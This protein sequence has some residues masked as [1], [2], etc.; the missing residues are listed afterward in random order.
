ML[1]GHARGEGGGTSSI[2]DV[3]GDTLVVCGM[4]QVMVGKATPDDEIVQRWKEGKE[5]Q[6]TAVISLQIVPPS[7]SQGFPS[8]GLNGYTDGSPPSTARYLQAAGGELTGHWIQGEPIHLCQ[9]SR[10]LI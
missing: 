1:Q 4:M 2:V 5:V 3:P 6:Q 9:G 7:P 8:Q 10:R